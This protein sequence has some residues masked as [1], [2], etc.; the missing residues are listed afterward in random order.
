[1][2]GIGFHGG[3]GFRGIKGGLVGSGVWE[4]GKASWYIPGAKG[5]VL[6]SRKYGAV[7]PK[8]KSKLGIM[9]HRNGG[10]SLSMG[11]GFKPVG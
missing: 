11:R 3:A 6:P 5:P 2:R 10:N 1:M 4:F 7:I 9:G 8:K